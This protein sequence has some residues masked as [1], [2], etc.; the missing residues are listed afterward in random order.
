M[1]VSGDVLLAMGKKLCTMEYEKDDI[2]ESSKIG[3]GRLFPLEYI[4]LYYIP[5]TSSVCRVRLGTCKWKFADS[6]LAL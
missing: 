3:R 1:Q 6:P 5:V 4:G 2:Q